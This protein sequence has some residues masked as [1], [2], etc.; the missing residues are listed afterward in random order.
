LWLYSLLN[1]KS[2]YT[3]AAEIKNEM[4]IVIR[5]SGR[6]TRHEQAPSIP[7][8]TEIEWVNQRLD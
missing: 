5:F 1:R 4:Y 3:K 6:S 7:E 8:G 2:F